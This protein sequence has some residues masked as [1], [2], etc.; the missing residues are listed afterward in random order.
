MLAK[1]NK[2]SPTQAAIIIIVV[3]FAVFF[4]GLHNPFLGDDISQIVN[5][6]PVHS[7]RNIKTFFEGG[8]FYNG[9]GTL[10]GSYYRPMMTTVFALIFTLFGAHVLAFHLVQ[11]LLYIGSAI[12]LYL[13]LKYSFRPIM[14]L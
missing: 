4:T 12:L 10:V 5:N 2:I 7:I 11:L 14:A 6:V 1:I 8:T 3:G 9:Q 13:F